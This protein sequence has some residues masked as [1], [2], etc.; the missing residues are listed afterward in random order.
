MDDHDLRTEDHWEAFAVATELTIEGQRLI[1]EE[2]GIELKL[3]WRSA[4]SWLR[5]VAG[6]VSRRSSPPI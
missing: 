4:T 5:E 3:L 2:I 6:M 1:A